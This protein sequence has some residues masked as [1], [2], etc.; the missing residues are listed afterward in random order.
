LTEKIYRTANRGFNS[1]FYSSNNNKGDF[2]IDFSYTKFIL[3]M[4][5]KGSPRFIHKWNRFKE[6]YKDLIST[7]NKK[8][9]FAM[10]CSVS[11]NG[12]E[13]YFNKVK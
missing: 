1:L 3:E 10:D 11:I 2:V 9:L 5:T 6:R 12:K 7:D 4:G 13:I 8:T